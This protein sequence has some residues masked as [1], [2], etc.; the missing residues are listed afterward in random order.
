MTKLAENS[1]SEATIPKKGGWP[2][3]IGVWALVEAVA[4]G[5]GVSAAFLA[6]HLSVASKDKDRLAI[7]SNPATARHLGAYRAH[8]MLYSTSL[9]YFL[10]FIFYITAII[11]VKSLIPNLLTDLSNIPFLQYFI[12]SLCAYSNYQE[13][14]SSVSIPHILVSIISCLMILTMFAVITKEIILINI[15]SYLFRYTYEKWASTIFMLIFIPLFAYII[16][17]FNKDAISLYLS[18]L[19]PKDVNF[20][21]YIQG[22]VILVLI[23]MFT[24]LTV[25]YVISTVIFVSFIIKSGNRSNNDWIALFNLVLF[26][27]SL[28]DLKSPFQDFNKMSVAKLQPTPSDDQS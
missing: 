17:L 21:N 24:Y 1:T 7:L 23:P 9:W 26:A 28:D 18:V 19:T 14:P 4:S 2:L 8:Q 20:E 6:Y 25:L 16:I 5:W 10:P 12:K 11:L 27:N 13:C 3:L 22:S 15:K